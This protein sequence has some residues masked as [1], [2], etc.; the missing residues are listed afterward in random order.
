LA[1]GNDPAIAFQKKRSGDVAA[2]DAVTAHVATYKEHRRPKLAESTADYIKAELGRI[3]D[4]FGDKDV[5]KV[6][7][8]DCQKLIDAAI[9]QCRPRIA[10]TF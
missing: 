2:D 7:P 3:T 6:T 8:N 4:G 5:A 10:P 1:A 9:T